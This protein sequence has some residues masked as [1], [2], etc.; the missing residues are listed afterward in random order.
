M[1][2]AAIRTRFHSDFRRPASTSSPFEISIRV[3]DARRNRI[4]SGVFQKITPRQ[5]R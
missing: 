2:S 1:L 4:I 5:S 3:Y